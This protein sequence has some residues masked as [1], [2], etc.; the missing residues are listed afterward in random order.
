[1]IMRIHTSNSVH[2]GTLNA[3]CVAAGNIGQGWVD[4]ARHE[5]H[6][7]RSHD[8]A[9]DIVLESD[10]TVNKRRVN[11]GTARGGDRFDLP[12]AA[13]WDQWGVIFAHIFAA[14]PGASCYAYG[15]AAD[16]HDKTGGRFTDFDGYTYTARTT[17][18]E[19]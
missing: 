17:L 6:G 16:F 2:S 13:T 3:A 8:R 19:S 11:P 14:D 1:M 9:W 18:R 7:S 12:Y 4:F 15:D 5:L 10:G